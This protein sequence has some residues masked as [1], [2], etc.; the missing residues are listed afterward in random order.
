MCAQP[1]GDVVNVRLPQDGIVEQ[2]LDNNDLGA[3]PDLL[4][5]I[6]AALGAGQKAMCEGGADAAT[7]EV[8]DLRRPPRTNPPAPAPWRIP[9][10]H[11][12]TRAA[13]A[14]DPSTPPGSGPRSFPRGCA[15][16][17]KPPRRSPSGAARPRRSGTGTRPKGRNG[18]V[19]RPVRQGPLPASL[20]PRGPL[21]MKQSRRR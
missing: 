13:R 6:Q 14:A 16:R 8:D 1:T 18:P 20:R 12:A 17:P 15:G 7:V 5:C 9:A 2:A 3:V 10:M 11:A 21:P 19:A 4:P